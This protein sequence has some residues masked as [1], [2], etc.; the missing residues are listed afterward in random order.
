MITKGWHCRSI[1]MALAALLVGCTSAPACVL[2]GNDFRLAVEEGSRIAFEGDSLTYGFDNTAT[3]MEPGMNGSELLRSKAPFPELLQKYSK[4]AVTVENRGFPGDRTTEALQRWST[5]RPAKVVF[6]QYG[7]NDFGNFGG[8]ETGPVPVEKFSENLKILIGRRKSLAEEVVVVLPPP[9][10]DPEQNTGLDVY[11]CAAQTIANDE[12]VPILNVSALLP[13]SNPNWT[14]GVH[15][16][17]EANTTIARGIL[18]RI[19][20]RGEAAKPL[21]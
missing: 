11:R 18:Q 7:T 9:L 6:I 19:D 20:I 1:G 21:Q 14:D 5:V 17:I 15:L 13:A 3:G 2:K 4:G 8:Y 10:M 16:T 12:K